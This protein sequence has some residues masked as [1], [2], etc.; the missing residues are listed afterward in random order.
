MRIRYCPGKENVRADALSQRDQDLP[1]DDL[2]DRITMRKFV[3]LAPAQQQ[4]VI[5]MFP[6]RVDQE[7]LISPT[8]PQ[9][10]NEEELLS[11]HWTTAVTEDVVYQE[12][13]HAV[14]EG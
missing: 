3:M 10:P 12:V 7:R 9:A 14:G 11:R 2:D 1:Q 13:L 8:L 6:V 5:G 4:E